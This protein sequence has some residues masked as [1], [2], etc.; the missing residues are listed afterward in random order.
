MKRVWNT[1]SKSVKGGTFQKKAVEQV[2]KIEK[3]K[4]KIAPPQYPSSRSVSASPEEK[5][6]I[7]ED[8]DSKNEELI[9]NM[10]KI[11]IK[12]NDPRERWISNKDLPTKEAEYLHRND[13][14]WEYAITR[15]DSEVIEEIFEYFR[16]FERK[17]TQKV[18]NKY[19]LEKLQEHLKGQVDTHG[20]LDAPKKKMKFLVTGKA[21]ELDDYEKLEISEKAKVREAVTQLR[22]E[23]HE[24]LNKR[25]TEIQQEVG[26][27]RG[28][29]VVIGMSGGVDSA[30]SAL[31]LK[32][33]GFN[34][35]AVHMINWD[36]LEE[37][38]T[39]CPQSK[40]RSGREK[41]FVGISFSL[42]DIPFH[43]VNFVK[44]YWNEVFLSF[45]ENY[46][47][48]RT[49]VPD[50]VCNSRIKFDHFQN[51][52]LEKM[53]ADFVATGHYATT[54]FGDFQEHH[55]LN[56]EV[57]LLCG[58]DPLKDQT[59]FLCT[60]QQEQLRRTMFPVGSMMKSQIRQIAFEEGLTNVAKKAESMGICFVGRKNKFDQ[61]IDEYIEQRPGSVTD[62][63]GVVI[64]EHDG[65]HH[66]TMGKRVHGRY[67]RTKSHLGFFVVKVE[68]ETNR[69]ITCEGSHHSSLYA[70]E[71]SIN[72]PDW[73]SKKAPTGVS[74]E[75]A[76][77]IQR[78]HPAVPCRIFEFG[79]N[80]LKVVPKIPLRATAPGQMCVFYRG[81]Q[82][83][84]G[85]EVVSI[86]KTLFDTS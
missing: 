53:N 15:V 42:L 25:L 75:I 44:E 26:M 84:G 63:N 52:A 79:E 12:S 34:V 38:T 10:N 72:I 14:V 68:A 21:R 20:L 74:E 76:C 71:F 30:V 6:K 65:I 60:V 4:V 41:E 32:K 86:E 47:S 64:G 57:N 19:E 24:R 51:F 36:P 55:S 43:T 33:R 48:G 8:L 37:G 59:Y 28:A 2:E 11:H 40:R 62:L 7:Q 3:G 73:I 56:K 23:E 46:R 39:T 78:A 66:F 69:V 80:R 18:V 45:L 54:S 81:R 22:K 61:F 13:P 1:L 9:E 70:T 82:C 35:T 27:K 85:G 67:L 49:V 31:L 83:L 16:P 29:R 5:R 58:A 50:I 17:D 77:R